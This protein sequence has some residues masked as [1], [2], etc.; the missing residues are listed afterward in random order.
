[1]G[2]YKFFPTK[3]STLYSYYVSRNAGIDEMLEV[4]NKNNETVD[5]QVARFLVKFDQ[6]DINNFISTNNATSSINFLFKNYIAFGQGYNLDTKLEIYPVSGSWDNGT[7]KFSDSPEST[8]GVSWKFRDAENNLQWNFSSNPYTTQSFN[9]LFTEQ[10]GGVWFTG[11]SDGKQIEVTQSFS[12]RST[13]DINVDVTDIGLAWYSS[14]N[15]IGSSTDIP[16]NGFLVKLEDNK[17]FTTGSSINPT[18][19]Y[20]STDTNT[21]YP[22]ELLFR[23]DDFIDQSSGSNTTNITGSTNNFHVS[24]RESKTEYDQNS[25]TKFRVGVRPKYPIRTYQTSSNFITNFYLPINSSYAIKD[26]DTN[27]FII[28]FDDTYTKISRDINENFFKVYMNG[29]EPERYY[30]ILVKTTHNNIT[31][32]I[33]NDLLFKVKQ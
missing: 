32:I 26:V 13:K 2:V 25:E 29:L 1:M 6:D 33:D 24:L 18:S 28:N 30:K 8:N 3:D 31:E 7:G 22:P 23:W 27:E 19:K 20:F 4:Y 21:I 11:S 15:S 9:S 5:P 17:E 16:N 10:G 14:S 12:L